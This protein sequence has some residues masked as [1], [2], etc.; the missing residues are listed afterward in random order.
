MAKL[1]L[2]CN[3]KL[4]VFE[5]CRFMAQG[6]VK[7]F[8]TQKGY[9]F[10]AQQDGGEDLFVHYSEVQSQSL[11]EG[12]TVEYEVGQGKKGPCAVNVRTI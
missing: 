12:Q 2:F 8:D 5:P 11:D 6:Q 4:A 9:G 10:I 1:L 7:W 3:L